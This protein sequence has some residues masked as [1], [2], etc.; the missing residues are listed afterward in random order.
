MLVTKT[1]SSPSAS[2]TVSNIASKS[3]LIVTKYNDES[4]FDDEILTPERLAKLLTSNMCDAFVDDLQ[5]AGEIPYASDF[6]QQIETDTPIYE[7]NT[8]LMESY[9]KIL[10]RL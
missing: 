4:M 3:K 5:I 9:D 2:L 10:S 8:L 6:D 7:T 1:E